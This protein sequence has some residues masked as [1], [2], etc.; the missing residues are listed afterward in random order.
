MNS[1]LWQLLASALR[2]DLFSLVHEYS[3]EDLGVLSRHV[4]RLERRKG[5]PLRIV[6][7]LWHLL[8]SGTWLCRNGRGFVAAS[9]II[10]FAVSK[11]ETDSL[12]PVCSNI[13]DAVLVQNNFPWFWAHILSLLYFPWVIVQFWKA[14]G[15]RRRSFSY[16]F[17]HYWLVYGLYVVSRIWLRRLG[18]RA[19]VLCN[20]VNAPSRVLLEAS[21]DESIPAFFMQHAS[22]PDRDG[23]FDFDYMLLDGYDALEKAQRM[24]TTAKQ[25]FLVGTPKYDRY[26]HDINKSTEVHSIAICTNDLDSVERAAQLCAELQ[27]Q[28]PECLLALRPHNADTRLREWRSLSKHYGMNFSDSRDELSF[29]FLKGVDVLIAGDSNILLEAALMN[30]YPLYYGFAGECLDWYGFHRNGLVGYFA[31]PAE[32]CRTLQEIKKDRPSVRM[33]A[34]RYSAAIGTY[35][36]GRSAE[37]AS[38]VVR[39]LVSGDESFLIHWRRVP[40]VDVEAYEAIE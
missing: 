3:S 27:E 14:R 20:N 39:G 28:F 37:L 19:V 5:I 2:L 10:F 33:N 4:P 18:P 31:C 16:V 11:N 24:G 32:L 25:I 8:R 40:D 13:P 34:K 22:I 9:S 29:E 15:Y 7:F 23:L 36:D 1:T 21:R 35:Y 26:I 17:D 38:R 6:V 12:Q 30:V